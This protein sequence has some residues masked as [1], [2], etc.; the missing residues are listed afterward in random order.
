MI[1]AEAFQVIPE[2]LKAQGVTCPVGALEK[3]QAFGELLYK[4]NVSHN[5]TRIPESEFIQKHLLNSLTPANLL[6]DKAL[7]KCADV[8]SGAGFPGLPLAMV[9]PDHNF[10]LIESIAKKAMFLEH[11][12]NNLQLR[13]V[14]VINKRAEQLA[15][16]PEQRE[17][18]DCVFARAVANLKLLAELTLPLC[19][20]NGLVCA[21]KG[22]EALVE[23][24]AARE[25]IETCG[26]QRTDEDL[27]NLHY[28]LLR[29]I[30]ETPTGYPRQGRRL[31]N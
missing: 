17:T 13:N 9:F 4:W 21:L 15:C 27:P 19:K 26:G 28:M 29:K 25:L 14:Q 22:E 31:G 30:K 5:L 3:L 24:Q 18:F 8:G 2:F 20:L 7:L 10:T 6:S 1:S 12:C 11:V 23:Y 16:L